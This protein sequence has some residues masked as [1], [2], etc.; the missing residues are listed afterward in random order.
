MRR[1]PGGRSG[2]V[3]RGRKA[4]GPATRP[5]LHAILDPSK[6]PA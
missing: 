5:L 6:I 4:L 1:L 2:Y 3:G